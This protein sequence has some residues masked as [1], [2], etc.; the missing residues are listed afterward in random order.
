MTSDDMPTKP[1]DAAILN[2]VA[3]LLQVELGPFVGNPS[4]WRY[5]GYRSVDA[6]RKAVERNTVPIET[7]TFPNRRGRF[8]RLEDLVAWLR[9]TAKPQQ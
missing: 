8:A 1:A 2:P 6:F 9:T 4:L 3:A 5:L 7:F